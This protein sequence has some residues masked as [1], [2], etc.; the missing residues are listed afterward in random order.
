MITFQK[1]M[2][3]SHRFFGE[4]AKTHRPNCRTFE[5]VVSDHNFLWYFYRH[6]SASLTDTAMYIHSYCYQFLKKILLI[7]LRS[8]DTN[9][10]CCYQPYP[11]LNDIRLFVWVNLFTWRFKLSKKFGG[12]CMRFVLELHEIFL[13]VLI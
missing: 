9:P 8:F 1:A 2:I 12:L 7:F 5:N 13:S 11:E 10:E 3:L 6:N 4:T